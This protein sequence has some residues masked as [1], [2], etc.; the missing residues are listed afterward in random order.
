M[1]VYALLTVDLNRGTTE[2]QRK[3]FNEKLAEFKWKKLKLTT[4]W[5]ATFSPE[6]SESGAIGTTKYDVA[7]AAAHARITNYEA[8]VQVGTTPPAIWKQPD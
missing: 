7:R 2:D 5:T 4:T 8:A 1:T 6:V 3:L